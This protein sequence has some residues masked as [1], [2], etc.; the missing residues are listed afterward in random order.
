SLTNPILRQLSDDVDL[1]ETVE[2]DVTQGMNLM[3]GGRRLS[4]KE[5]FE[6]VYAIYGTAASVVE[7]T[8]DVL[9][10]LQATGLFAMFVTFPFAL[11]QLRA[12]EAL[13]AIQE[14]K[15]KLKEAKSQLHKA[16]AK[17]AIDV[18]I[19][20]AEALIPEL[21]LTARVGI[22]LADVIKDK[23]LESED[24]TT[25]QKYTGDIVPGAKQ[26][27]EAVH[28]IEEYGHTA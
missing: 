12:K 19:N 6:Q 17:A 25:A 18:A 20:I 14:L 21:S 28:H 5:Q 26:F 22:Y 15:E 23:A 7:Q 24:A 16:E 3:G 1:L 9:E 8:N 27:C 2:K 13:E 11:F 10:A 4:N